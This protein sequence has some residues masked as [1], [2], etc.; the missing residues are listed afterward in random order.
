MAAFGC[1]LR[2]YAPWGGYELA[3]RARSYRLEA[4]L[5]KGPECWMRSLVPP[6]ITAA[7]YIDGVLDM[8]HAIMATDI[9]QSLRQDLV[10]F[11]F[12]KR[13]LRV[14]GTEGMGSLF[15]RL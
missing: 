12:V 13:R 8:C 3:H 7:G 5:A 15:M 2:R 14:F 10:G 1:E 4:N 11:A 6:P 9:R